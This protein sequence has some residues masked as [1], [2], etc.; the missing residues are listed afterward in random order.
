MSKKKESS[1]VDNEKQLYKIVKDFVR[2]IL[3]TFPECKEL[4]TQGIIDI[5]LDNSKAVI[6]QLKDIKY[7]KIYCLPFKK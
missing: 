6:N 1:P 7:F 4:L 3:I 5:T 2:D